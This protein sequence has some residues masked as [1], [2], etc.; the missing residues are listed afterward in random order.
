MIYANGDGWFPRISAER[1][2]RLWRK[3]CTHMGETSIWLVALSPPVPKELHCVIPDRGAQIRGAGDPKLGAASKNDGVVVEDR[4][5]N[6]S[7][8]ED[9]GEEDRVP[10]LR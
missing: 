8:I 6:Q 3:E 4:G 1:I 10:E 9:R 2:S 7:P 5:H